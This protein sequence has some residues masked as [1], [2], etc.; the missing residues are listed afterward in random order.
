MIKLIVDNQ[1]LVTPGG[2]KIPYKKLNSITN[3]IGDY[4]LSFPLPND[5][6]GINA[7]AFGF[8]HR[9]SRFLK[10]QVTKDIIIDF[11]F[12]RIYSSISV[13]SANNK[14]LNCNLYSRK[15]AFNSL[16]KDKLMSELSLGGIRTIGSDYEDAVDY[17]TANV[18][19]GQ[20]ETD[21]ACFPIRNSEFFN[22]TSFETLFKSSY[23]IINYWDT[24][25]LEF[26]KDEDESF[27][28]FPYLGYVLNR[29]FEEH[30]YYVEDNPFVYENDLKDL[31][32]YNTYCFSKYITEE[33]PL[34]ANAIVGASNANPCS[35]LTFYNHN[36]STN[37]HVYLTGFTSMTALNDR[38]Y[39]I[40]KTTNWNYELNEIDS[41]SMPAFVSPASSMKV[42]LDRNLNPEINLNKC[43]T[44]VSINSFLNAVKK[45]FCCEFIIDDSSKKVII[46]QFKS[47]YNSSEPSKDI[48]SIT[49]QDNILISRNNLDGYKFSDNPDTSDEY[50]SENVK[51]I[52]NN[53][54]L[55]DSVNSF[56]NLPLTGNNNND[57]RL[58]EDENS[59]YLYRFDYTTAGPSWLFYTKDL[60]SKSEGDEDIKFNSDIST[61]LMHN[62]YQNHSG[63]NGDTYLFPYVEQVG[64][65]PSLYDFEGNEFSLRLLFYRGLQDN[66]EG[67][68]YPLGTN[69]IYDYD[70]NI[71]TGASL[72]LK[73][74]GEY[75]LH[76]QLFKEYIYWK[77]NNFS[78]KTET[79]WDIKTLL[80]LQDHDKLF[81]N[82]VE[83]LFDKIEFDITQNGVIIKNTELISI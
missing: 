65:D 12:T 3:D 47:I 32:I 67:N 62:G 6:E 20:D 54:T 53:M 28:V 9:P 60:I 2:F 33:F 64:N 27:S 81:L 11:G 69:S 78:V 49:N 74:D 1:R 21:F 35:I 57:I 24:D 79:N 39:R 48:T 42:R 22:D 14:S 5:T 83:Y 19:K 77:L 43:M 76:E 44:G 55:K 56:D 75:G 16:V 70:G 7:K 40:T 82:G 4:S 34:T 25:N 18:A 66:K 58:V 10:T 61:V 26:S 46:K 50:Y 51:E 52:Q 15:G 17:L 37:D 72:E 13:N 68:S 36:L 63:N 38:V 8:T 30:G 23:N 41:S 71:I 80:E 31:T 73:Y 45:K 59:Y 29:I